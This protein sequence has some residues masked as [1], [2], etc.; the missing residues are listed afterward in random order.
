M[1]KFLEILSEEMGKA[2]EAAGYDA[3]LEGLKAI[4]KFLEEHVLWRLSSIGGVDRVDVD[5]DNPFQ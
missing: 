3:A 4:T 2:F 1:K 5:G